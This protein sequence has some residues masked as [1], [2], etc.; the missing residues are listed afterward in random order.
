MANKFVTQ[1]SLTMLTATE[2]KSLANTAQINIA[3]DET[4]IYKYRDE[5]LH[6]QRA[7]EQGITDL[8]MLIENP[9]EFSIIATAWGFT[10]TVEDRFD[11][12]IVYRKN[13]GQER[14]T[15]KTSNLNISWLRPNRPTVDVAYYREKG[16]LVSLLDSTLF[17]P[18]LTQIKQQLGITEGDGYTVAEEVVTAKDILVARGPKTAATT[19]TTTPVTTTDNTKAVTAT[20]TTTLSPQENPLKAKKPDQQENFGWSGTYLI[21]KGP[22]TGAYFQIVAS[23]VDGKGLPYRFYNGT[24]RPQGNTGLDSRGYSPGET[25]TIRGSN[26]K[27]LSPANNAVVT[28]ETV[29][30]VGAI[31]TASISGLTAD[32][33]T[34]RGFYF[35]PNASDPTSN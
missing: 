20:V 34:N 5:F 2:V 26:F 21:Y 9:T 10:C 15:N 7:A 29:N 6:I 27:G 12:K 35:P 8:Y 18:K 24:G 17:V 11:L 23:A 16:N 30:S 3:E 28:V 33:F 13:L 22:G 1:Q 19:V 14:V 4:L 32:G 25:I 31:L